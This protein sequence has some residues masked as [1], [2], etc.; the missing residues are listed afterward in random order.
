MGL[1]HKEC[2]TFHCFW[3][4]EV[5]SEAVTHRYNASSRFEEV[6]LWNRN[7]SQVMNNATSSFR[8]YIFLYF[9]DF[10]FMYIFYVSRVLHVGCAF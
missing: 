5:L 4:F 3:T 2:E 1:Y 7:I 9:L 8:P 6:R 10:Y